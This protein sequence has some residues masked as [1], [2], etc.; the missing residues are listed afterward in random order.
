MGG[1]G[2][3][4][5]RE[6]ADLVLLDDDFA[7]LARAIRE[8][9]RVY[10]NIRKFVRYVLAGNA[11]EIVAVALAPLC[12]MPVPL[13]PV[14]ILWVNLVTDGLLGLALALEPAEANVMS[15]PPRPPKEGIF[16]RGLGVQ[17]LWIGALIGGVTLAAQ[18][19][20]IA[21][22]A[23][24]WRTVA[25]NVLCLSQMGQALAVRTE[26]PFF[27]SSPLGNPALLGAVA[28]TVVLQA[29]VT[30]VPA[31]QSLFK[32]RALNAVEVGVV[33]ALSAVV[34]VAV[35]VAKSVRSEPGRGAQR[36]RGRTVRRRAAPAV[37]APHLRGAPRTPSEPPDHGAQSARI[38]ARRSPFAAAW[39]NS[40]GTSEGSR[41]S[42]PSQQR[43]MT[44]HCASASA[45]GPSKVRGETTHPFSRASTIEGSTTVE[46]V[47]SRY[48][49]NASMRSSNGTSN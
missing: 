11:G 1:S 9:R 43:R 15:R 33:L 39:E 38:A 36:V 8:G 49:A 37:A 45:N 19:W 28:L 44:I 46:S 34:F 30:Y 21:E 6:A 48:S 12:G 40:I 42:P 7:T 17:V 18:A 35:E 4:V 31:L 32:T 5:A 24:H 10:D 20:A 47:I 23:A 29:A 27:R 14:H 41:R 25:F 13:L 2:T 16:A 3:D 26:A 22:G